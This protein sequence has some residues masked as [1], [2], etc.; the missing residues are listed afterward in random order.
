MIYDHIFN[1]IDRADI[2]YFCVFRIY[3]ALG[4][5]IMNLIWIGSEIMRVGGERGLDIWVL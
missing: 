1:L 2:L 3:G 4:F 5:L